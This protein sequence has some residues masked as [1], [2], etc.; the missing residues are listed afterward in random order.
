L[1]S[2]L[3]SSTRFDQA[4][5]NAATMAMAE[6][7]RNDGVQKNFSFGSSQLNSLSGSNALVRQ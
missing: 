4:R 3:T 5:I 7:A 6:M 1:G 2:R